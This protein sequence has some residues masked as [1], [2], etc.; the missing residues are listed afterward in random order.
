MVMYPGGGHHF[1]ETGK[2]SHRL[3][4]VR[5]MVAWV[6]QWTGTAST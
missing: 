2:P 3:D 1:F 5:R 6:E 4:V